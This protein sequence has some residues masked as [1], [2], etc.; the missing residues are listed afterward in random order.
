MLDWQPELYGRFETERTLPATD[1]L[2]RV[3]LASPGYVVDLGCGSGNST[4]LLTERFPSAA[5]L[6]IDSSPAML[7]AA[8]SRLPDCVFE[9]ADIA[10]WVPDAAPELIFANAA[11]QWVPDHAALMPRLV[12]L[13]APGGALAVQMPDN[14]D[15]ASH[16][17][18]H[19][20]WRDAGFTAPAPQRAPLLAPERYCELL[21]QLARVEMWRTTYFHPMRSVTAVVEWL[22][23]TGLRPFLAQLGKAQQDRF[24]SLYEARLATVLP[25]LSDGGRLL[26]FPRFF[27]IAQRHG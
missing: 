23:A 13:L 21:T 15:A 11:L 22:R 25:P 3:R 12:S 19:Q 8:C 26:A 4:E 24:L 6:G 7:E 27:L 5:V 17:A 18:M 1:L 9:R 10:E 20:A 16:Q 2:A 14:L